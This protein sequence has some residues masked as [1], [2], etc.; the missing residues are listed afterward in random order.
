MHPIIEIRFFEKGSRSN[1]K[2][3]IELLLYQFRVIYS[4]RPRRVIITQ[5]LRIFKIGQLVF[6]VVRRDLIE[7]RS[8]LIVNQY[9]WIEIF[10]HLIC[11]SEAPMSDGLEAIVSKKGYQVDLQM[12]FTIYPRIS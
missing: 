4:H 8:L 2:F 7:S 3:W 9:S 6:C 1:S 12:R 5:D 10:G 11:S